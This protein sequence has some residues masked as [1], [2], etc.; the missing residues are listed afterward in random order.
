[1]GRINDCW[2]R[3]D[4]L[5][6]WLFFADGNEV[7]RVT[8]Q[9]DGTVVPHRIDCIRSFEFR[10]NGVCFADLTDYVTWGQDNRITV[11]LSGGSLLGT[12]LHY[13]GAEKER[14]PSDVL[15]FPLPTREAPLLDPSVR[16][17][18]ATVN[19]DNCIRPEADN[20]LTVWVNLPVQ[21]LEGV[22]ASVPISIGDSG[23]ELRCDMSL[24]YENGVWHKRFRS[25]KRIHLIVDDEKLCIWAVSKINTESETYEL[26][27]RWLF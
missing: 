12:Y 20:E 8:I 24:D 17:E 14:L 19:G 26:P 11:E 9:L 22:Y 3:P 13:P 21:S 1:M 6:L 4:R 18:S 23:E 25:G 5:W 27:V 10:E 15:P 2:T 7:G 16:I